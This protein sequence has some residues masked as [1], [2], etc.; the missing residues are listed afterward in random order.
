MRQIRMDTNQIIR[1]MAWQTMV[2]QA[3]HRPHQDGQKNLVGSDI[4]GG[5][6]RCYAGHDTWHQH[7][8]VVS[9]R[10]RYC[11]PRLLDVMVSLMRTRAATREQV[12]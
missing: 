2:E 7:Q 4:G 12:V 3:Q 10:R 8:T 1:P 9:K 6:C 11:R 5:G